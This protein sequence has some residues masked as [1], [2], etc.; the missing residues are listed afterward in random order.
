[1]T[2]TGCIF[3]ISLNAGVRRTSIATCSRADAMFAAQ[4][5][6]GVPASACFRTAM[7]WLSVKRDS[8]MEIP[9]SRLRESS[10]SGFT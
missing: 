9:R 6:T 1:M 3:G 10:T 2:V 7:I 8:S 5:G 4:L